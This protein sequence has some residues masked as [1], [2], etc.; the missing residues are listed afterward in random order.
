MSNKTSV[1]P[2][3]ARRKNGRLYITVKVAGK[4]VNHSCET[5]AE[6][7]RVRDRL[8]A[9]HTQQAPRPKSK[10]AGWL[11]TCLL[12]NG[13]KVKREYGGATAGAAASVA[14]NRGDVDRVLYTEAA[15]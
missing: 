12:K 9:E 5:L 8:I 1:E 14:G 4:R 3:I 2:N 10:R 11:C 15:T 6:A 13:T 7:R